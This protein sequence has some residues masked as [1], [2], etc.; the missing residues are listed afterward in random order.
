MLLVIM[1]LPVISVR[2]IDLTFRP[3]AL[4]VLH[5]VSEL[6]RVKRP[7]SPRIFA[8]S[9]RLTILVLTY[10]GVSIREYIGPLTVLETLVP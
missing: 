7:V 1:V 2:R 9:M 3:L 6:A 8:L 5:A 10:I 4:A